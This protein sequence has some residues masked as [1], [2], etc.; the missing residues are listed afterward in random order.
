MASAIA[1]AVL[2]VVAYWVYSNI[3]GLRKNIAAAK[4]SGLP[5]YVSRGCF[6]VILE[7]AQN[8]PDP[9]NK[10][11]QPTMAC[12]TPVILTVVES[13]AKGMD[14]NMASVS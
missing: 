10:H 3:A 1:V 4:A 13:F 2:A 8:L 11:L 6:S 14:R 12:D 9:S 5:Y 7:P